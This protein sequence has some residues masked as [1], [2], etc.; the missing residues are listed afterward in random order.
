MFAH[1]IS[2]AINGLVFYLK[3]YF[4]ESTQFECDVDKVVDSFMSIVGGLI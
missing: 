1:G 4:I 2:H 3:P